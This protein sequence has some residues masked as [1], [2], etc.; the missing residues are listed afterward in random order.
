MVYMRFSASDLPFL[1]RGVAMPTLPTL[2]LEEL[3]HLHRFYLV[4]SIQMFTLLPIS[5]GFFCPLVYSMFAAHPYKPLNRDSTH[6]IDLTSRLSIC[7]YV[8]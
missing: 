5:D 3:L 8:P 4:V 7:E 2:F 6:S 1:D